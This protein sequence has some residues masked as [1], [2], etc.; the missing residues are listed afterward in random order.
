MSSFKN[1]ELELSCIGLTDEIK[2]GNPIL[3]NKKITIPIIISEAFK[4]NTPSFHTSKKSSLN[5]LIASIFN[6]FN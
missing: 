2:R 4:P 5:L 6:L 3:N 1:D